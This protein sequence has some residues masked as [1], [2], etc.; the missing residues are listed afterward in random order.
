[1]VGMRN[2]QKL[3]ENPMKDLGQSHKDATKLKNFMV[4]ELDW[5]PASM[6]TDS[7]AQE[8]NVN[9]AIRKQLDEIEAHCKTPNEGVY[10]LNFITFIGHGVIND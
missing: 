5:E 7:Q 3:K 2:Y 6:L 10:Y 4:N 9:R 8:L 1:M